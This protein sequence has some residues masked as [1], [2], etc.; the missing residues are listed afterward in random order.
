MYVQ[1]PKNR[2]DVSFMI[3]G[4]FKIKFHSKDF[5]KL[6]GYSHLHYEKDQSCRTSYY[7]TPRS[8]TGTSFEVIDLSTGAT[9]GP[10]AA[11]VAPAI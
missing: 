11:T 10:N 4:I 5:R 7:H 1:F 6:N 3:A 9:T 2:T 8:S